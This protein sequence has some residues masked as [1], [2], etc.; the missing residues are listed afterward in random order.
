VLPLIVTED[1]LVTQTPPPSP[2]VA[3]LPDTVD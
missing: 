3:G 1:E 2:E